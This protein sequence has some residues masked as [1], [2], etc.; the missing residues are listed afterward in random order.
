MLKARLSSAAEIITLRA[1]AL[2]L[3]F[4]PPAATGSI[5]AEII[6]LRAIALKPLKRSE[7]RR[8]TSAEIITLR[9]IALK[10]KGHQGPRRP[11]RRRDHNAT[12]YSTETSGCTRRRCCSGCAEI[13]T[14]RAIALK[15]KERS[16]L[17][18]RILA[19]II[20]LR[21]IALKLGG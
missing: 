13:I 20:T 18:M 5:A 2:K 8:K 19:E 16:S 9:A 7:R 21:A 10:P 12:S 14:L 6:T 17:L 11:R 3:H 1:I 4:P 15:H